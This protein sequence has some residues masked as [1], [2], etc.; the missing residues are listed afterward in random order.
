MFRIGMKVVCVSHSWMTYKD[1]EDS[2]GPKYGDI[3][4]IV[5]IENAHGFTFLFFTE[6]GPRMAYVSVEFRPVQDQYTEEEIEAV[7]I[8]ELVRE[9]EFA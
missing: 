1:L 4:K 6:Y 3:L 7:N 8:D 9:K 2:H 5:R